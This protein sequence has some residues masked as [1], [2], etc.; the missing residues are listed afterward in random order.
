MDPT[1]FACLR[2][3]SITHGPLCVRSPSGRSLTGYDGDTRK[4]F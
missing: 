2:R 4:A 1:P 3:R